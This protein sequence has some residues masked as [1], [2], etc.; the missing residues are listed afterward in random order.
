MDFRRRRYTVS[1]GYVSQYQAIYDEYGTPPADAIADEQNTFVKA[2]VDAG[3]WTSVAA[4][5]VFANDNATDA[6]I[7]WATPANTA[8][9]VSST[10]FV[11]YEGF[12]SDGS[13]SYINLNWNP[14]TDGGGIWSQ[15]SA[16]LGVYSRTHVGA[17]NT[18]VEVGGN[19]GTDYAYIQICTGNPTGDM[20]AQINSTGNG[21]F[22]NNGTGIGMFFANRSAANLINGYVNKTNYTDTDASTG[23]PNISLFACAYNDNGSDDLH[24]DRQISFVIAGDFDQSAV[25][26]ITDAFE[27]Y[28]DSNGKGVIA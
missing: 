28:M 20:F 16:G 17:G 12:T 24:S 10:S 14:S 7:D 15:N 27:V 19:D 2:L 5:F 22:N 4:L 21:D 13:N 1:G 8:T 18:W 23:I 6:L 26:T 11:A 25:N 3:I 9:N